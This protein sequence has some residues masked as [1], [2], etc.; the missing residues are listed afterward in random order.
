MDA[1]GSLLIFKIFVGIAS[2]VLEIYRDR[3]RQE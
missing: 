2:F 3:D 1:S